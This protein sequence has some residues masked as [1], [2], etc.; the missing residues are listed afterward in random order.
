VLRSAAA[1]GMA[2]RAPGRRVR[3]VITNNGARARS[4]GA[5]GKALVQVRQ[6]RATSSRPGSACVNPGARTVPDSFHA[7]PESAG[8][9]VTAPGGAACGPIPSPSCRPVRARPERRA[10]G[11]HTS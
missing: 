7:G 8:A 9:Q 2:M 4:R 10:P 6:R 1:S 5:S 3:A 11:R